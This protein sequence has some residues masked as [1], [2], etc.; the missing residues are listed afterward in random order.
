MDSGAGPG[1]AAE[2]DGGARF[3]AGAVGSGTNPGGTGGGRSEN[4]CAA[5]GVAIMQASTQASAS[6]GSARAS[7]PGRP[8]PAS[9][10]L[11]SP[12]FYRKRGKFKP[13]S[14][15]SGW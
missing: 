3:N 1:V 6:A 7:Y 10:A 9:P 11:M 8:V 15:A 13:R 5:A 2:P 14:S 4:I 12:Y